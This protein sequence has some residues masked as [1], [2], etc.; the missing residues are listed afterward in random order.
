MW[1]HRDFVK[2]WAA[3]MVSLGGSHVSRLAMPLIAVVLL[4]ASASEMGVI[5]ALGACG[6][7]LGALCAGPYVDRLPRR[8][9]MVV[10]D[11]ARGL[12]CALIPLASLSGRLSIDHLYITSFL[13]GLLSVVFDVA[14]L[15]FLATLVRRDDLTEAN[16]KLEAS[17]SV[18]SLV[19]PGI[20]GFLVQAISAPLAVLADAFSFFFSALF[21]RRITVAEAALTAKQQRVGWWSEIRAGFQLVLGVLAGLLGDT[22]GVRAVLTLAGIGQVLACFWFQFGPIQE[23]E[24]PY[25][26][27]A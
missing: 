26:Y 3:Q 8:T 5:A 21:L 4:Q 7:V 10:V 17:R 9:V 12:L 15:S 25:E 14:S 23:T 24:W 11:L 1:Q 27:A 16:S 6:S 13:F 19:G 22:I 2:L 20:A 18:I